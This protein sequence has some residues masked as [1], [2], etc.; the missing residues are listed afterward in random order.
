MEIVVVGH[1]SRD[2]I[3]TPETRR[4]LLGGGTAYAM[5]SPKIGAFGSGIISRVGSDFDESYK[6]SLIA[7]GLNLTGLHYEGSH[8]TRFVNEYDAISDFAFVS[9][10]N[11][12]DFQQK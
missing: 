2:L 11:K 5:L 8:T 6:I 1:L 10:F 3:I 12:V 4:E 9:L 7:S